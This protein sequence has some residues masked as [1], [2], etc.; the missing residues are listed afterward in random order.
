MSN[1]AEQNHFISRD[2]SKE[3]IK[4]LISII[5]NFSNTIDSLIISIQDSPSIGANITEFKK[6]KDQIIE[7][8]DQNYLE[9]FKCVNSLVQS[10]KPLTINDNFT[11]SPQLIDQLLGKAPN[12]NIHSTTSTSPSNHQSHS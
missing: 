5:D 6:A 4:K 9:L 8:I 2:D 1:I 3:E 12:T 11:I 10:K 7:N